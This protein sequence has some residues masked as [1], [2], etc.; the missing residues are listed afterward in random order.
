METKKRRRVVLWIAVGAAAVVL[1][2]AATGVAMSLQRVPVGEPT[3]IYVPTDSSFEAVTDSLSAHHCLRNR[4]FFASL[5][6]LRRYPQHV[7]A[8]SYVVEPTMST[9]QLLNK[10]Y[11][12]R[13]DA[14]RLVV[15]KQR[16]KGALAAF[17]ASRLEMDDASLLALLNDTA[18]AATLGCTVDDV[19]CLF[20]PNSYDVYWNTSAE[21]LL[22]RMKRESERFW[23]DRRLQQCASLGLSPHEVQVL[24]SIVEEET[25]KDDEKPLVAAVYLNRL[26]KGMC[27]QADPTLRFAV[28]D[29]GLRR[30]LNEHKQVES[31]YNTYLHRGLPPGPICLASPRSI[32]AVLQNYDCD[33]LYFCAREDFS[34]Y[35]NFAT[36]LA[37]HL[38]NAERYHHALNVRKIFR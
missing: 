10:L 30:I 34:G 32:D 33:Y 6:R 38:R 25:N 20:I 1:A 28:G 9:W 27:L 19:M 8:G 7:K 22:R 21:G 31:P 24:A 2:L 13:Q 23:T 11:Y 17:V 29:F 12:G 14:V 36:T 26:R 37:E 35:H 5:A 16:T 3:R 4:T 15:G 18:T